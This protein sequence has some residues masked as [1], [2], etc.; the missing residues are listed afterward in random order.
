M[1]MIILVYRERKN[2]F[3]ERYGRINYLCRAAGYSKASLLSKDTLVL[4]LL[5]AQIDKKYLRELW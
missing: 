5:G 1:E 3:V 2:G 4:R